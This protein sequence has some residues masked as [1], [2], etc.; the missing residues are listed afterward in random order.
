MAFEGL[1][2]EVDVL[3]A[4]VKYLKGKLKERKVIWKFSAGLQNKLD[5]LKPKVAVIFLMQ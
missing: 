3:K 4:E 5:Q 1:K 2:A